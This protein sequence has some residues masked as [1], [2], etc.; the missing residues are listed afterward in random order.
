MFKLRDRFFQD[1]RQGD[2]SAVRQA[3]SEG[4]PPDACDTGD[5][6]T[7]LMHAAKAGN[8]DIVRTLLQAGAD[9]VLPDPLA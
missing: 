7:A 8:T 9:P 4:M 3:L 6:W 2:D 5:G 1:V